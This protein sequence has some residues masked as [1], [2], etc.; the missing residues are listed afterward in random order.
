MAMPGRRR[1]RRGLADEELSVGPGW[2]DP[3]PDSFSS[4]PPGK[5]RGLEQ[6]LAQPARRCE[7]AI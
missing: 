3:S 6:F 1:P 2:K 5:M 7:T 4:Y